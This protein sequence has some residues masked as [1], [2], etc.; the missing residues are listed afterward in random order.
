MFNFLTKVVGNREYKDDWRSTSYGK[1]GW[2]GFT[3]IHTE[4]PYSKDAVCL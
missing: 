1:Q 4:K 2:T 3:G